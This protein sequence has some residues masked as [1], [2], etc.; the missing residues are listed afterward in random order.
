MQ[1]L[2]D[3][4]KRNAL[5]FYED[6]VKVMTHKQKAIDSLRVK[7][8]AFRDFYVDGDRS[9]K[10]SLFYK[11]PEESEAFAAFVKGLKADGGGDD[12]ET[13]LEAL[14]LALKS[15]WLD[16]SDTAKGRQ[17]VVMWTDT[18][19]HPL[20]RQKDS[21]PPIYP[22]GMPADFNALTDWWEGA[23]YVT[24]T[25]KRLLVYAPDVYPWNNIAEHWSNTVHYPSQAGHGLETVDY[26]AILDAIANSI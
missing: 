6:L 15:E 21:K 8:I 16:V 24:A 13:S 5:R 23:G 10:V 2:I 14:A 9:L 18:S 7:V 26:S 11:L 22:E 17:V 1:H 19:S 3:Q 20:E 25:A 4:V 12:P